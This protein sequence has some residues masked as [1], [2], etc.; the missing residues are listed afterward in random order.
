MLVENKKTIML[1][2]DTLL[3]TL[4][5]VLAVQTMPKSNSI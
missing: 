2:I 1:R 4:N 3:M 5:Y